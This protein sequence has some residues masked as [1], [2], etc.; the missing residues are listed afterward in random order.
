M[1]HLRPLL[2]VGVLAAAAAC[3]DGSP[4]PASPSARPQGRLAPVLSAGFNAKVV[5]NSYIVVLKQGA[6]ARS[7]ASATGASPRFVYGATINGF[8][9]DLNAGQINALQHNPA[10][11]YIEPNAEVHATTTQS[12][13]DWGL[14]RLDQRTLPLSGTYTYTPTGAGVTAY[15]VDTGINAAN[16]DFGGRASVGFD[17]VGDGRNG[18]DCNG[19]GT[20]VAGSVGGTTYGVAKGVKIVAVRVLDCNGSG[21]DATVI[22]GLNWVANN[23]VSPSVAN[24]SLGG[25][26]IS[27]TMSN[28]VRNAI[29]HGTLFA[30]AAGNDNV[31]AC[32]ESPGDVTEA[33]VVGAST[34]TD[35]RASYSNWGTCVDLFAPGDNIKST[36]MGSTTATNTI[37][38][39][40]MASPHVA[41][42]AALYLQGNPTATPATVHS[43]IVSTA[44]INH[45]TSIGTGSPNKLLSS[46][47]TVEAG[48]G[49]GGGTDP[50]TACTKYTGSL[51]AA[52]V[53]YQPN[54][55]YYQSTVSGTHKGWLQG[56]TGTDFDLY[57][58]KWNGS[59]W[60]T[61]ASSAGSTS[62][63][64]ISYAGT[65]GY[66]MWEIDA[67][68]GS[69]AY[70]VWLQ[71]P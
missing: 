15:I 18:V 31:S 64:S 30:V 34:S 13:P 46:L 27:T 29:S 20:H 16:V 44:S 68:S 9:G 17:A 25:S 61:V 3:S 2:A 6:D 11:D 33:L 70:S 56:P 66:Y 54:G 52:G 22:A 53:A 7:V 38:G 32:T 28:A 67:Y 51:A 24:M 8:A 50:C 65:S 63:E 45:L 62:V 42:V 39:T 55:T 71:H 19:H 4:N 21:T 58:L 5:P 48:G 43:A 69:G 49:T 12:S 37:S 26:S 36:W 40:S 57:L 14:D 60:V 23:H 41:G 1:R 10:V 35:A 59:S 47:L